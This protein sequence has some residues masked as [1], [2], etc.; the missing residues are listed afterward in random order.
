[1]QLP[2][3]LMGARMVRR[4]LRR[5]VDTTVPINI[6]N[7]EIR[8]KIPSSSVVT[9]DFRRGTIYLTVGV[10][11]DPPYNARLSNLAWNMFNRFR[12]EQHGQY[13]EDRQ[14]WN[15]QETFIY[16]SEA[17][18]NQFTTVGEG[19]YGYG[20]QA[21]RN[22]KSASWEYALPIPTSALT[23]TV[24]PWFQLL[25]T[26]NSSYVSSTLPD[27][28]MIWN[29]AD[30][31]EWVEIY[32][33]VGPYTNLAFQITKME[34]EYEEI[35]VESGNTGAFLSFWH[36][37]SSPFPNIFWETYL[38]NVYPLTQGTE[39]FINIDL[40]VKSIQYIA[41]TVRLS[42]TVQ[43]P[44]TFDKFETWIGPEDVRW[45]LMEYQ[46]EL[47]NN[48]WPDRPISLSDPGDV[49]PYKKFLEL[50]G[51]YYSR[52]VHADVTAIGPDGF[53]TDKF[54]MA[55]D[56][57]MYPFSQKMLG[58]VS[59]EKSS[60]YVILRMKFNAP[61]AANLELVVHTK[62]WRKWKFAAPAGI[63]V[64]W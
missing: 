39:Q 46:W 59:T 23:K 15:W 1:M 30:P 20:S 49:Q 53:Q 42:T 10:T 16:W 34:V 5:Q 27:V 22:T 9:L 44:A 21:N 54:I 57:N 18:P 47:N 29:V 63:I 3:P 31:R 25:K 24:Y 38:T 26:N 12:L 41:C 14:F 19:L 8:F 60:K 4:I 64:D 32:G 43:D 62:Y 28:Y 52:T 35:T 50:F 51:N 36:T 2:M 33:A 11:V 17:L 6:N 58:P 48:M 37:D 56:A 40:R 7:S 45:P 61:P 55:F 13:I